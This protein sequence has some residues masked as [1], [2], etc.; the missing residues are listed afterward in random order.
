MVKDV[1]INLL[2]S[3]CKGLVLGD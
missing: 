2:N 3:S 1:F